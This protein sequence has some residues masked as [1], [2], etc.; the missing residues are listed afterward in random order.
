L[1]LQL[2]APEKALDLS[3]SRMLSAPP[4]LVW[5]A[6]TQPRHLIRWW[7]PE[8]LRLVACE[9]D[10]CP[11]GGFHTLI[12]SPAGERFDDL[13]CFLEVAPLERLVWTDALQ[14]GMRPAPRTGKTTLLNLEPRGTGSAIRMDVLWP[15]LAEQPDADAA[16]YE[17]GLSR[18]LDQL[19]AYAL[20][21]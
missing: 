8:P 13:S 14:P 15:D 1:S 21:L 17:F 12:R 5:A 6:F 3:M 16:A 19:V 2:S 11:G 9:V 20:T 7:A 10:L 18:S 4:S